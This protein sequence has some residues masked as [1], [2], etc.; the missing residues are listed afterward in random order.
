[1][2]DNIIKQYRGYWWLLG[3]EN[4]QVPGILTR[5]TDGRIILYLIG[6]FDSDENNPFGDWTSNNN[7]ER[8]IFGIDENAKKITLWGHRFAPKRNLA[9]AFAIVSYQVRIM[10]YGEHCNSLTAVSNFKNTSRK[11]TSPTNTT[12]TTAGPL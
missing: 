11:T 2:Q 4:H 3:K 5:Y 6:S 1:M 12:K 8:T 10:V 9:C 7:D